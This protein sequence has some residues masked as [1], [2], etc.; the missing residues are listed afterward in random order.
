MAMPVRASI[1]GL[2]RAFH[3]PPMIY[4]SPWDMEYRGVERAEIRYDAYGKLRTIREQRLSD[5]AMTASRTIHV[6]D[7]DPAM[8]DSLEMLLSASGFTVRSHASAQAFLSEGLAGVGCVLTD[9]RMPEIDGLE[10][11]RRLRARDLRLPVIVMTGQGDIA[12]AVRAMKAGAVDFLEKPFSDDAL[13]EAIERAVEQGER[14]REIAATSA[15][16]TGAPRL[17]D[18]ARTRG[19]GSA[20]RWPAEQGDRQCV[21]RQPP[22][23]RGASRAGVRETAGQQSAGS[24]AAGAGGG[25]REGLNTRSVLIR[26]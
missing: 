24:G 1:P 13:F 22:H 25:E 12:I 16:A 5:G 8:R 23:D 20:G 17:A 11:L 19:A 3:S 14:L 2:S 4:R 21:G 26:R 9:V 7:D 10:L 6:V 18:P 15:D